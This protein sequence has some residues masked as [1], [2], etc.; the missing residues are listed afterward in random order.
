VHT[1]TSLLLGS[2]QQLLGLIEDPGHRGLDEAACAGTDPDAYH[3]ERGRP[4]EL[5][6]RRCR[7]CPA[8]LPCLALALRAEEPDARAGWY[9]GLGPVERDRIAS[10]LQPPTGNPAP[11]GQP[12]EA[13]RLRTAGHTV[14]EIAAELGCSRRTVQR[15][16]RVAREAEVAAAG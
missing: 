2:E 10:D 15:Y 5:A 7:G 14:T 8:R 3:P 9:G 12:V 13:S 4:D 16:L 11:T 6:L 1:D